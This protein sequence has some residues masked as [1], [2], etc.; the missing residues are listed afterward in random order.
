MAFLQSAILANN[1]ADNGLV[2]AKQFGRIPVLGPATVQGSGTQVCRLAHTAQNTGNVGT[3]QFNQ[4]GGYQAGF[5]FVCNNSDPGNGQWGGFRHHVFFGN[6]GWGTWTSQGEWNYNCS[7]SWSF[8]NVNVTLG[9]SAA[10]NPAANIQYVSM[11]K[12]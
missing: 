9:N 5:L 1:W 3:G 4:G 6:F 10:S 7:Q 2:P 12:S 8:P 11:Q